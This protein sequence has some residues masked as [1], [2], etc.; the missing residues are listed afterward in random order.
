MA[1]LLSRIFKQLTGAAHDAVDAAEDVGRTA[2][3]TVREIENEIGKVEEAQV[4]VQAEYNMLQHRITEGQA[5]VDQ[6]QGYAKQ[7]LA[8]GNEDLARSAIADRQAAEA[9]LNVLKEQAAKFKPDLDKL[10]AALAELREKRDQ[11]QRDT[12]LIEARSSVAEARSTA[13][14]VLGG[15]GGH[16][17]AAK[18]FDSLNAKVA[19]AEAEADARTQIADSK[20]AADPS[21][22]YASLNTTKPSVEDELAALRAE[23]NK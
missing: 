20:S 1:G 21:K 4:G 10:N 22:K 8:Q 13:A 6:Y 23:V 15:I 2:R 12:S 3:Q 11:M 17:S 5:E 14:N 7:A 18:T 16:E 9:R 19:R